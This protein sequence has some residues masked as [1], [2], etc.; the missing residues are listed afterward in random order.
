MQVSSLKVKLAAIG[1]LSVFGTTSAFAHHCTPVNKNAGAGSIGT[2]NVVHEAF[3]PNKRLNAKGSN[4]GFITVTDGTSFS[5]DVFLHQTL[6]EGAFAAGPG[7]DDQCD[8]RGVDDA[9][10]CLGIQH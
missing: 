4:G 6:P 8:D 3:T 1:L 7:G 2:Y 5:Y 10:D 9:L